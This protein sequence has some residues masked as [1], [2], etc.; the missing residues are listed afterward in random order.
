MPLSEVIEWV[1]TPLQLALNVDPQRQCP[2]IQ[3]FWHRIRSFSLQNLTDT[4]PCN[5]PLAIFGYVD[6]YTHVSCRQ[7]LCLPHVLAAEGRKAILQVWS[8]PQSPSFHLFLDKITY[9]MKMDWIEV[10]QQKEKRVK[11]FFQLCGRFD[12]IT[13]KH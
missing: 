12:L 5:A 13:I 4:L 6:I 9:I 7:D 8:Q 3:L 11:Q 2:Q 1:Y 10:A